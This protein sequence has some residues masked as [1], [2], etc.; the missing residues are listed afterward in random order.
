MLNDF[1]VCIGTRFIFGKDV[2]SKVG[3][4][5]K[6]MGIGRVLI[7]HDSGQFLYD[8][9]LLE[10][11]KNAL[12]AS[13]IVITELGGVLPNPR[14]SLVREGIAIA[15]REKCDMI[16]AIG[17]GS[18]IDSAKAIA[19]GAVGDDVWSYFTGERRPKAALPIAAFVTCPAAGS[20]SSAVT[21][22]NNTDVGEKLLVSNELVRPVIAFME[23]EIT[24]SLPKFL[25]ACG[26]A[27]MFSHVC[28][29]YF[30]A[31]E[32][33][34]VM[35]R[36]AEG[37]LKTIVELGQ[38]ALSEPDNYNV[39]AELMW[40]ATIAQNN[41]LGLGG[42]QDWAT[43]ELGN[44][45]SALYDTPHGATISIIMGA[46]MRYVHK[47]APRRFCRYAKKVFDVEGEK[48]SEQE[49]ALQGIIKTEEFFRQLGLPTSFADF[50][51]PDDG[52]EAMLDRIVF[53]APDNAIGD[54]MR[55]NRQSCREI[56][57]LALKN[58]ESL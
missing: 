33:I 44:E 53:C 7:H 20:E 25:T 22:I 23:P 28:E 21:V 10:C 5:L 43:H 57:E 55:L 6:K 47:K 34:G 40:I 41:T 31:T 9:G 11:V 45:L 32:E 18:A 2:K 1:E 27:D 56:Y 3:E 50:S 42:G 17:G 12:A 52:I 4:Q 30:S 39:R 24:F 19:L 46:W 29:R 16:F 36:M 13:G 51:I 38:R 37:V 48:L 35:D 58:N 54:V 15:K 8:S 14:L 26:I 49:A